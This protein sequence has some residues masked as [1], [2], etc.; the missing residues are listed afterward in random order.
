MR[1]VGSEKEG[2]KG[3]G[4]GKDESQRRERLFHSKTSFARHMVDFKGLLK[5]K[6][7]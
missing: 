2:L 4:R 3:G 6:P 1:D 7:H 5:V